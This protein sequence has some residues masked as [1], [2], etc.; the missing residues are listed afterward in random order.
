MDCIDMRWLSE[1]E[2]EEEEEEKIEYAEA[3]GSF[4]LKEDS[5]DVEGVEEERGERSCS[6]LV[7]PSFERERDERVGT[8]EGIILLP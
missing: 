6:S 8:T 5:L 2:E 4:S 7:G 1:P 3:L